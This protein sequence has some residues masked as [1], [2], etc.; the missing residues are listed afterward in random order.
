[1]KK[2][3][4][5]ILMASLILV[6]IFSAISVSAT[7]DD[8]T[9]TTGPGYA[10]LTVTVKQMFSFKNINNAKVRVWVRQGFLSGTID[11]GKTGL[12]GVCRF[13]DFAVGILGRPALLIV[14][15]N[16]YLPAIC[17]LHLDSGDNFR[18]VRLLKLI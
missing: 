2:S 18:T 14:T 10:S 15:A 12:L 3:A 5:A 1:M 17:I 7:S 8:Q 6:T 9:D 4:L 13:Y 11:T 16:G